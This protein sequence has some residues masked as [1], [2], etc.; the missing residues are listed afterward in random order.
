MTMGKERNRQRMATII[1]T[2]ATTTVGA[3]ER[4]VTGMEMAS[5]I[6]ESPAPMRMRK[7]PSMGQRTVVGAVQESR[8]ARVEVKDR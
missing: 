5:V 1:K 8:K 7:C 4:E 3:G 6:S 2:A